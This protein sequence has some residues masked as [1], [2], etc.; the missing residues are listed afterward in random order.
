MNIFVKLFL[1]IEIVKKSKFER[2]K[3]EKRLY[4]IFLSF[5]IKESVVNFFFS[6]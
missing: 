6:L 4:S 2:I 5:V 1:K 3:K